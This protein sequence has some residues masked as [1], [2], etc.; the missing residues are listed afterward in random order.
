MLSTPLT[1]GSISFFGVNITTAGGV[2]AYKM[3]ITVLPLIPIIVLLVQ[4]A[5][6]VNTL[7]TSQNAISSTETQVSL[8]RIFLRDFSNEFNL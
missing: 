7:L 1:Y 8:H 4:N 6:Y 5:L 3:V 2:Q